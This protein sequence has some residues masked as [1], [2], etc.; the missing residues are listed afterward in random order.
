[1]NQMDCPKCSSAMHKVDEPS[2][3]AVKCSGC[4]GIFFL[5]GSHEDARSIKGIAS[6]DDA[7]ANTTSEYN[8]VRNIDCPNCHQKMTKM[9]D[10]TQYHINFEACSYCDSVF[11]DAG[12][13]KDFTKFTFLGRIKQALGTFK[14]N[15]RR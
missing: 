7:D 13:F 5:N 4:S 6:I 1:M 9:V 12:E 3:N 11:F 14:D 15:I 10:R 2:L 8:A